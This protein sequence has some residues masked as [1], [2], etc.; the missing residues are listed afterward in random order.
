M[1]LPEVVVEAATLQCAPTP[2]SKCTPAEPGS[3]VRGVITFDPTHFPAGEN[4]NLA[5][6]LFHQ[7]V[8]DPS[9]AQTGGHAHAYKY[10][11]GVDVTTG[12]LTFDIDLCEI[13]PAMYSEE[14]CTFNLVVMLDETGKNNPDVYGASSVVVSKGELVKMTPLSIS[15]HGDSQCLPITADCSTG[16]TCTTYTPI[17][18]SSCI[19]AAD[20]CPSQSTICQAASD[21]GAD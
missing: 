10:V 8:L 2:P 19:C 11:K 17:S 20:S 12:Q 15:C 21:A 3:V 5:I 16:L 4:V 6:F 1:T 13:G 14:N 18:M 9:E 7:W